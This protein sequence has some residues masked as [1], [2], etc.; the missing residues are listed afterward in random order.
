MSSE[1][2]AILELSKIFAQFS[3]CVLSFLDEKGVCT[4]KEFEDRMKEMTGPMDQHWTAM[5]DRQRQEAIDEMTPAQKQLAKLFGASYFP[6]GYFPGEDLPSQP[7][8]E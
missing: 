4:V 3:A 8:G 6:P 7:A 2:E 1:T 5:L